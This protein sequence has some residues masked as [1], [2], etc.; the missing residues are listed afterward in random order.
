MAFP[1]ALIPAHSHWPMDK[2]KIAASPDLFPDETP[3]EGCVGVTN[4]IMATGSPNSWLSCML[5][6][7]DPAPLY[8]HERGFVTGV[9]PHYLV[10]PNQSA[11]CAP[12]RSLKQ[13]STEG[14]FQTTKYTLDNILKKVSGVLRIQGKKRA[15]PI[16]FPFV[17][18]R[19]V[20]QK[21]QKCATK[22][23]GAR[24]PRLVSRP[25][26][27]LSTGLASLPGFQQHLWL[28]SGVPAMIPVS[29]DTAG[30]LF[31]AETTNRLLSSQACKP[32]LPP[33]PASP[34]RKECKPAVQLL[35]DDRRMK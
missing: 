24:M 27:G 18:L 17:V 34:V 15:H 12:G 11:R 5:S 16:R 8:N 14:L 35:L 4:L 26:I 33:R 31:A 10:L 2:W 22:P 19:V 7:R 29:V 1:S 21:A 20:L 30:M 23:K 25:L 28:C 13:K 9:T 6:P 3:P 32:A